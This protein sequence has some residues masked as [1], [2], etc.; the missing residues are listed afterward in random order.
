M[1]L[2]SYVVARDFAFAPNPFYGACTLATCKPIVRRV[3][4]VGDWVIGT[5]SKTKSR[6]GCL[7]YCMRITDTMTF[8]QY[9]NNDRFVCKRPNL[10]G[11]KKQAFGDNIYFTDSD[12]RWGQLNSH[13]SYSDGRPNHHN[14]IHDTS[15]DRVLVSSDFAYWGG[16]GPVIP[17]RFRDFDGHDICA[18]RNHRSRFPEE[19]VRDFIAWF[20]SLDAVGYISSPLDWPTAA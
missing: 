17:A 1:K 18:G 8:N 5:G 13:H 20:R 3:A 16:A 12:G 2:F 4:G 11:S 9:W 15:T 6:Q 14:I 19:L 10:R 7:V